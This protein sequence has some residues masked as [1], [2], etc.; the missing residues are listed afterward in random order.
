MA[1]AVVPGRSP[2][3]R[4]AALKIANQVRRH[5][6]MLKRDIA[7]GH[8]S[9]TAAFNDPL[10]RSMK[11]VDLLI[12]VPKVGRTKAYRALTRATVSPTKT[13]SGLTERQRDE[14]ARA[15]R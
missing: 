2:E 13:V 3:Q 15:I 8:T 11:V 1:T 9:W 10:C 7:A 12:S 5:R 4:Q 6:A 14:L